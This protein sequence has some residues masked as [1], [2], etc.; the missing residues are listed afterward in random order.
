MAEPVSPDCRR[1]RRRLI[2][3]AAS[4]A[5]G[6][7]RPAT[8]EAHLRDCAACARQATTLDSIPALLAGAPLYDGALHART[9]AVVVPRPSARDRRL[10]WVVAPAGALA[11]TLSFALPTWLL[12]IPLSNLLNSQLAALG[13]ALFAVHAAGVI[14][15]G[16]CTVLVLRRRAPS[17]GLEEVFHE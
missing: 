14:P 16:L 6:A 8:V 15:A 2:D 17:V 7:P 11:V 5:P 10:A 4:D 3:H 12:S 1:T 13:L 9:L